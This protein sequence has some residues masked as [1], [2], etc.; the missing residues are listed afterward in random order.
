MLANTPRR[1]GWILIYSCMRTSQH[2]PGGVHVRPDAT[3]TSGGRVCVD[4][5]TN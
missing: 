2:G 1:F 5:L 4:I 3:H